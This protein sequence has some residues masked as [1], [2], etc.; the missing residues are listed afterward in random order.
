MHE[1]LNFLGTGISHLGQL[2]LDGLRPPMRILLKV[3]VRAAFNAVPPGKAF[4]VHC[5]AGLGRKGTCIGAYLMKHYR[6][7]APK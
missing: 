1:E 2:Y 4:A 7:T 3:P 6:T 5:N